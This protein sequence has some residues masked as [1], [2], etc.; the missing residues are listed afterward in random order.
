MK[1][2]E[3]HEK[4]RIREVSKQIKKWIREKKE[5]RGKNNTED[6]VWA[7]R[8]EELLQ[9]QVGEKANF[10]SKGQKQKSETINTRKGIANVVA[11]FYENLFEDEEGEEDKKEK[12]TKSRAEDNERMPDQF[13]HIPGSTKKQDPRCYRPLQER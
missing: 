8:T 1:M 2:T 5:R 4:E 3:K 7:P 11:E 12:K 9:Y 10:H 13:N 6:I